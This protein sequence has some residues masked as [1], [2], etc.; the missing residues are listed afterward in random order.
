LIQ[1]EL[2]AI[3]DGLEYFQ[4]LHERY[5]RNAQGKAQGVGVLTSVKFY[6]NTRVEDWSIGEFHEGK[7]HGIGMK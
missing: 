5:Y 6:G 3:S 1:P 4:N 2:K 7:L